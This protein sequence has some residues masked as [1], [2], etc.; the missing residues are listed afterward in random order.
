MNA[1]AFKKTL[2]QSQFLNN[3]NCSFYKPISQTQISKAAAKYHNEGILYNLKIFN[4]AACLNARASIA[5]RMPAFP[6]KMP[7]FPAISF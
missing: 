6:T 7:A 1:R 4:N 2:A 3:R 5:G